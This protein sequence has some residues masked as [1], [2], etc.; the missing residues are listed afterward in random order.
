VKI[1]IVQKGDTLWKIAQKYG[2]DFEELKKMNSQLSNPDLIMPGMKIKIPSNGVPVKKETLMNQNMKKEGPYIK[3]E[4]PKKEMPKKELP[5][6]PKKEKLVHEEAKPKEMPAKPYA[7]SMPYFQ[8][9]HYPEIDV[10]NHYYMVNMSMPQQIKQEPQLPPKP[11]NVL[12]EMFKSEEEE[13]DLHEEKMTS[14][15]EKEEDGLKMPYINPPQMPYM[16]MTQPMPGK[17]WPQYIAPVYPNIS[18]G[19]GYGVPNMQSESSEM[20]E[21]EE[22]MENEEMVENISMSP[23][24]PY[25]GYPY[26]PQVAPAYSPPYQM[27]PPG[28]VPISPILPGTGVGPIGYGVPYPMHTSYPQAFPQAISPAMEN[29]NAE[30]NDFAYGEPLGSPNMMYP[31][32]FM[33]SSYQSGYGYGQPMMPYYGYPMMTYGKAYPYPHS[34]QQP[35]YDYTRIY[36]QPEY[37]DG[38]DD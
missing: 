25:A 14:P 34:P 36:E 3:K 8:P 37:D 4:M 5:Y 28:C 1:H 30:N 26:G 33:P 11:P 12:P 15:V 21:Y 22:E 2:V 13:K 31:H 17:Q 29:E 20:D 27:V 19:M 6:E 9:S 16:P 35:M 18:A 23:Y 24:P 38:E 32:T 7:P 10:N